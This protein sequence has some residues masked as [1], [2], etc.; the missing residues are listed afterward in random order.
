ME[1]N[2]G[3]ASGSQLMIEVIKAVTPLTVG[4]DPVVVRD[5]AIALIKGFEDHDWD[6]QN[7]ALG[8]ADWFDKAYYYHSPYDGGYFADKG[9]VN[10]WLE[11][12]VEA[13]KWNEGREDRLSE[14]ED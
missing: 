12:S 9:T 4:Q 8:D 7:E 13:E 6:T 1:R 3:W 2:M 14:N 5:M 10:P 11:D